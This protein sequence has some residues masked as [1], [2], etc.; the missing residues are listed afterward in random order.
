LRGFFAVELPNRQNSD[1]SEILLR[2]RQKLLIPQHRDSPSCI[3][4]IEIFLGP[5]R[6]ASRYND[7]CRP[8]VRGVLAISFALESDFGFGQEL[9]NGSFCSAPGNQ[10][11]L[12]EFPF[13]HRVTDSFFALRHSETMDDTG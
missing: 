6:V 5:F 11:R 10:F 13:L 9:R 8:D 1:L 2:F 7:L 3:Q 4:A 12:V